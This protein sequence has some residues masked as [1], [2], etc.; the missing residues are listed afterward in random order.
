MSLIIILRI[1]IFLIF[2]KYID[3][4]QL[5]SFSYQ[6]LYREYVEAI[7]GLGFYKIYFKI[8]FIDDMN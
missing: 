5:L 1:C 6:V 3:S 2:Y 4:R 7:K 8:N